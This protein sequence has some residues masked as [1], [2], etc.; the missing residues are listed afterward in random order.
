MIAGI[1]RRINRQRSPVINSMAAVL[2]RAAAGSGTN[3]YCVLTT[4]K[5]GYN[6]HIRRDRYSQRISQARDASGPAGKVKAGVRCRIDHQGI[7][8]VN[9]MDT[10]LVRTTASRGINSHSVLNDHVDRKIGHQGIVAVNCK[11]RT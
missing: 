2:V 4:G 5:V 7:P 9:G 11:R 8:M 1:R 3:K 10:V 6:G